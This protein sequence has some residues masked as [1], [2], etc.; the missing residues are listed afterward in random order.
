MTFSYDVIVVGAG[1]AGCEAALAA[2]RMGAR[3]LLLT[4]N[5]DT[6]GLMSC[7]PAIGGLAKGVLVREVEALGGE[8]ARAID[9]TGIQFRMLNTSKGPAVQAL[10]AQADKQAYRL[11]MKRAVERQPGLHL[12]QGM[13]RRLL[14]EEG[15]IAGAETLLREEFRARAVVLT[16]GTFTRGLLHYGDRKIEGGR[17]GE[18]AGHGLSEQLVDMG[19]RVGRLKTGTPPRLDG[20]T[21]DYTVLPVQAGDDPPLP[22]SYRTEAITQPQLPCWITWTNPGTHEIIRRNLGRA[23]MY[24]G[25]IEGTGVR[26][27][28]SIEDKVMRFAQKE[29]HQVF[30]EPE[31]RETCEVYVN[32]ISTSLPADVQLQM[33][34]T[35]KGLERAEMMRAGYAVEYDFVDPTELE[36]SL[37]TKRV[38]GLFHAGQI[39]GTTGYEEAAA[40]GLM[41]G[42]NAVRFARGE[43][44]AVL[45][46][47]EAYIGVLVD[48]L[49]TKGTTEP[50]RMFT[51]RAEHR[52]VL[53]HDNADRRLTALGH[54][55]SSV[56]AQEY[57][58]YSEK[59]TG[60]DEFLA[61]V[62]SRQLSLRPEVV[63]TLEATGAP[64]PKKPLTLGNFLR[65]PE[66]EPETAVRLDALQGGR[67]GE[68]WEGLDRESRR[69]VLAEVK[70]KEYLDREA[71]QVEILR[72]ADR[73]RI[74]EGLRFGEV[75]HLTAEVRQRLEEVRPRTLGQAS[76]VSGVTP[77]A[78]AV[79]E[80]HLRRACSGQSG[81]S[82]A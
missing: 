23:P 19:F 50:Y 74:P 18:G 67:L 77:A 24:N 32:G 9:A 44:A 6:V 37:M 73:V 27:C 33:V 70:Y 66:A 25:Q 7:N 53:R 60:A 40:Q 15:R 80:V 82:A 20:K 58:K 52:L 65:R 26:Y 64:V 48:D 11:Y 72:A 31:G 68:L 76:R 3:A 4:M 12:K 1:H 59:K 39:N 51:S 5:L 46:R 16:P 75:P 2:A 47:E 8:M 21:I 43:E 10:R 34:R 49:V 29:A 63:S 42:I 62:E 22:F 45:G 81:D 78:I 54:R 56:S 71:Q 61:Y 35:I 55:L 30:L 57:R 13:L 14:V 41:A 69:F 36:P 79:L 17:A 28:P 38:P